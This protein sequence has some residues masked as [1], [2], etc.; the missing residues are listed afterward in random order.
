MRAAQHA[1]MMSGVSDS[2]EYEKQP[3]LGTLHSS[4][5]PIG[6]SSLQSKEATLI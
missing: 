4:E 5:P 6:A 2:S 3:R 1:N